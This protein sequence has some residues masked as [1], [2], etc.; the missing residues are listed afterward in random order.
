MRFSQRERSV[1]NHQYKCIARS[2]LCT[3]T[4]YPLYY[5][6]G[7]LPVNVRRVYVCMCMSLRACIVYVRWCVWVPPLGL[8]VH[9]HHHSPYHKMIVPILRREQTSQSRTPAQHTC[10]YTQ[11]TQHT[12]QDPVTIYTHT[13]ARITH[14]VVPYGPRL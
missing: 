3:R 2:S 14:I 7:L 1:Q 11:K 5:S 6:I 4:I 12:S 10:I 8:M 9:H 13:R